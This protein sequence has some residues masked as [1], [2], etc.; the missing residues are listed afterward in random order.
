MEGAKQGLEGREACAHR[1]AVPTLPLRSLPMMP[2]GLD[3]AWV[4]VGSGAV[5]PWG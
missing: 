2:M 3:I 4:G 5:A 1:S